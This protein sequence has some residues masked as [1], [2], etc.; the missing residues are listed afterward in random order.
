MV[1]VFPAPFTPTTMN[2]LGAPGSGRARELDPTDKMSRI[3]SA[4]NGVITLGSLL[5]DASTR[6]RTPSTMRNVVGTY[7]GLDEDLLQLFVRSS[8]IADRPATSCTIR[9]LIPACAA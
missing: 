4:T 9:S 7:I 2:T 3:S 8:P 5:R 1:V 6:L